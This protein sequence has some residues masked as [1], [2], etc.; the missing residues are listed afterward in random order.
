MPGMD[1]ASYLGV[2]DEAENA[3]VSLVT[4]KS[5]VAPTKITIQRLELTAAVVSA[6]AAMMVQE[7]LNY[8]NIKQ[9]F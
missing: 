4:G 3:H 8:A 5:R 1:N 6:E 9:Y 2:K 7:E